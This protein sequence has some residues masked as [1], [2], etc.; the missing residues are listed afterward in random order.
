[1][2][3]TMAAFDDAAAICVS[4]VALAGADAIDG[5]MSDPPFLLSN[6]VCSPSSQPQAIMGSDGD[7]DNKLQL[8]AYR[9]CA[10]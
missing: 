5:A 6:N 9:V 3:V 2:A 4:D 10:C 1:M 7:L 8:C